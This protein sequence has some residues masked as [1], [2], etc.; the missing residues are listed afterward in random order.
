MARGGFTDVRSRIQPIR[1]EIVHDCRPR[2]TICIVM[3]DDAVQHAR[4]P[5]AA[6]RQFERTFAPHV[7]NG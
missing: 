3:N 6:N 2:P 4:D 7:H 5:I 1:L